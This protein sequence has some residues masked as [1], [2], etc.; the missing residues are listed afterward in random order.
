MKKEQYKPIIKWDE[1]YHRWN[2]SSQTHAAHTYAVVVDKIDLVLKCNCPY[3]RSGL[4][5]K[6]ESCKHVK[7]VE[8]WLEE[9]PAEKRGEYL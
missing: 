4:R 3:G 8:Q 7:A 2:V 5:T 9:Q 6:K 1:Y